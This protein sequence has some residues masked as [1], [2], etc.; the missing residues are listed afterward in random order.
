MD[1]EVDLLQQWEVAWRVTDPLGATESEV[2]RFPQRL[3]FVGPGNL[4][5]AA[6]IPDISSSLPV[7]LQCEIY[8]L[9]CEVDLA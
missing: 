7:D 1:T 6:E 4:K 3:R 2:I 9:P 5:D 8:D